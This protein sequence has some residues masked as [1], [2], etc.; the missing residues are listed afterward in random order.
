LNESRE[1]EEQGGWAG[2]FIF[3]SLNY[4]NKLIVMCN[5][6]KTEVSRGSPSVDAHTNE[7]IS[8][9]EQASVSV[10]ELT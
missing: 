3:T 6:M 9:I 7:R 5:K 2:K 8:L 4:A 1:I 10:D